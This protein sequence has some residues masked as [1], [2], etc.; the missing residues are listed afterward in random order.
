ML[1]TILISSFAFIAVVVLTIMGAYLYYNYQI[2]RKVIIPREKSLVKIEKGSTLNDISKQLVDLGIIDYP[3][4]LKVYSMLSG[5]KVIKAGVFEL[6]NTPI[7]MIDVLEIFDKGPATKR[8][9]FLE[10]W[11]VNEY[12]DYLEKEMGK[13]FSDKFAKSS[14]I[15]EGYM[16]PDTYIVDLDYDPENLASTMRN[17]FDKKVGDNI[18][19]QG[20]NKGLTKE[21]V[22]ILASVV[23]REMNDPAQMPVVAGILLKRLKQGWPLQVD[24][25]VQYAL[26][27]KGN[28]WPK[29][30]GSDVDRTNSPYNSYQNKGL[31]PTPIA[32]PSIIAIKSV[33]NA[34]DTTPYYY[35]LTA[36]GGKT[37]YSKTVEEHNANVN[38]YL[39]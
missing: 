35:Y 19:M 11:R 23:E 8:L 22:V 17:T 18:L 24:A 15:K 21:E 2:T 16:Y 4:V 26:G 5:T 31:P 39:K 20:V 30:G 36:P 38:K 3:E 33:I 12:T 25:T 10:G 34:D 27:K 6:P 32:N 28:W 37:Y 9:T 14:Y 13:P 1:K 29:I 7:N